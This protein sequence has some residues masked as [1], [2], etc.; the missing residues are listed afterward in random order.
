MTRN[1]GRHRKP[2][3][4]GRTVAKVAVTGMVVGA[5]LTAFAGSASAA[6]ATT[7]NN[8]DAVAQCESGGNWA[9]NTGNGFS[10]GL[11]FTPST[12]SAYGGTGSAQSASKSEQISV[13][14]RVLAGQGKGAWPVC[15]RGLGSA[16]AS[17]VQAQTKSAPVAKATPK[18]AAPQATAPKATTKAA[19]KVVTPEAST[20]AATTPAAS[21]SAAG[22]YVVV[23]G[24]TLSQIAATN[25]VAGGYQA[26]F[27]LNQGAIQNV[28][29]I[30]PG[31][32]LK[33]G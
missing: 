26:V 6:P 21:T 24:D 15:G 16:N 14:E 20:P 25:G 8:W 9:I 4:T 17:P 30:F 1:H 2:T 18:A 19:P 13:A 32:T 33:L 5:P 22:S 7:G 31:Q 28:D 3:T 11:Q 29:L 23:P 27:A 12:W 10:G